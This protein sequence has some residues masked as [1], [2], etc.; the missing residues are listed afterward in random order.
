MEVRI[1]EHQA[2]PVQKQSSL[3]QA[4]TVLSTAWGH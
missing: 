2:I 1:E 4:R 3:A